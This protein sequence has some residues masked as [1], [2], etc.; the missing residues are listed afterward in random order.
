MTKG[1]SFLCNV[2]YCESYRP[3]ARRGMPPDTGTEPLGFRCIKDLEKNANSQ[4]GIPPPSVPPSPNHRRNETVRPVTK[5]RLQGQL[6]G[7]TLA[8]KGSPFPA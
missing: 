5:K 8:L 1:G 2:S 7:G 4:C 3:T 6:C